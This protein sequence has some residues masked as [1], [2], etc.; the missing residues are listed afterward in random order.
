MG[1]YDEKL[2]ILQ[3][4]GRIVKLC[5]FQ[6]WSQV[7]AGAK[8]EIELR[9]TAIVTPVRTQPKETKDPAGTDS[10]GDGPKFITA[11]LHVAYSPIDLASEGSLEFL[12][13]GKAATSHNILIWCRSPS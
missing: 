3:L 7:P 9:G 5:L 1:V 2:L 11:N 8:V 13:F 10:Q 4:P 12:T 6:R